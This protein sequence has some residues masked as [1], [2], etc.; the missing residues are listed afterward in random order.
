MCSRSE[1]K[2]GLHYTGY[3]SLAAIPVLRC[4]ERHNAWWIYL[5]L[6]TKGLI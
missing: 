6:G 4:F 5:M 2:W 3:E 1:F